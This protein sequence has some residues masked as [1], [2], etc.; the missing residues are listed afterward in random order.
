MKR[1]K[2]G[3][4]RTIYNQAATKTFSPVK[5][6]GEIFKNDFRVFMLKIIF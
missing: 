6:R 1:N 3:T 5:E 2:L 4:N